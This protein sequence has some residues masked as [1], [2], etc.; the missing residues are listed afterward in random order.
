MILVF[1]RNG[2]LARSFN[3]L[4]TKDDIFFSSSSDLDLLNTKEIVPYIDQIQPSCIINCSAFNKVDEAEKDATRALKI[5]FEAVAEMSSYSFSNSIPIIHF[6]SDYVFDG[7]ATEPYSEE[8][9]CRPI[10]KYGNSKFLGERAV[11]DS[12]AKFLIFRTSFLYS[13]TNISFPQM[14][15]KL[16]D[17]N[18]Q[19]INGV[20]DMITSPT[21]SKNLANAVLQSLPSFMQSNDSGIYHFSDSGSVSR[22]QFIQELISICKENDPLLGSV[23]LSPV[24]DSFF[25]LPA[26]RP[27]FST[28]LCKK[29]LHDFDI[30]QQDWKLSLQDCFLK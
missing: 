11:I 7:N 29:I 17:E 6:S 1:G 25:Q 16:I 10:N 2:Q 12:N 28:L 30:P 21:Y 13:N 4:Y 18:T 24:E 9:E 23:K 20:T 26:K 27:K 14:I 15:K 3:E 8:D 19:T 22:F 5:N